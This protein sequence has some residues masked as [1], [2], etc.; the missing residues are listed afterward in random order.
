[1]PQVIQRAVRVYGSAAYK[2]HNS[3]GEL[4]TQQITLDPYLLDDLGTQGRALVYIGAP[5][6]WVKE[7]SALRRV[8]GHMFLSWFT[9]TPVP[10]DSEKGIAEALR[11]FD[12]TQQWED[13]WYVTLVIEQDIMVPD[14]AIID[15]TFMWLDGD[16][17]VYTMA[18]KFQQI[19]LPHLDR[20][21]TLASTIISPDAFEKVVISDQV[22]FSS[23]G[24][25]TFGWPESRANFHAQVSRSLDSLNLKTL[26]KRLQAGT[27]LPS[28]ALEWLKLVTPWW[29]AG[30]RERESWRAFAQLFTGLELLHSRLVKRY[31]PSVVNS[32]RVASSDLTSRQSTPIL[33]AIFDQKTN[34]KTLKACGK[35]RQRGEFAVLALSL[36]PSQADSDFNTFMEIKEVRDAVAHGEKTI[37]STTFPVNE[38]RSLFERYLDAAIQE[39]LAPPLVTP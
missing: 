22:Y 1:V 27:S 4:Q 17:P 24:R 38:L 3:Q 28:D 2:D 19:T 25:K 6:A 16:V 29:L 34:W 33:L 9:G 18:E 12:T 32:A 20:L 15:N 37:D 35:L 39:H 23:P 26:E 8:M 10:A 36:F 30:L 11:Q 31:Y 13:I 5:V 14:T 21:A 7:A